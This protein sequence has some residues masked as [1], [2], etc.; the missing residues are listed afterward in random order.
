MRPVHGAFCTHERAPRRNE[1]MQTESAPSSF[2]RASFLRCDS[3]GS[4]YYCSFPA[5]GFGAAARLGAQKPTFQQQKRA[6][7]STFPRH[8]SGVSARQV[9]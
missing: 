3:W 1:T 4:G 6:E 9:P 5:G 2:P 8:C 7:G